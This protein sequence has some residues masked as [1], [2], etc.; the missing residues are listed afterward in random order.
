MQRLIAISKKLLAET[1]TSFMRYL[2]DQINWSGRMIGIRGPRGVGKT[3][4]MLQHIVIARQTADSL[5]VN[6]DDIYFA[7]HSLEA[8]AA[9]C[10]NHGI[11]HLYIDEVHKYVDWSRELKLIYD[12]HSEL[13][14]IFSGSSVLDINRGTADLT[15]RAVIYHLYGLSL[16]EY[17]ELFEGVKVPTYT[18]Q[19]ILQ[20]EPERTALP[21]IEAPLRTFQQYLE[22]G[23]Y[24]FAMHDDYQMK[25]RQIVAMTL[26]TDIPVF[27]GMPAGAARKLKALLSII[28]ASVPFKPNISKLATLVGVNRNVLP[29]Y[30]NLVEDAGMIMQLK[31][32]VA[33]IRALGKVEKVYLDNPNLIHALADL[34]GAVN[35]GNVRETFFVNQ[36]RVR[37]RV[38]ASGQADFAIGPY[39]FEVGGH[40]KGLRQ[41][42]GLEHGYV[43]KDDIVLSAG[44]AIPLWWFGLNY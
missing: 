41:I 24:P 19:Q 28:A 40:A 30:I 39:D 10:V 11:R 13:Q 18:L 15:R 38:T 42:Q 36:M 35:Q 2:Y 23:Y 25:L 14:V 44:R 27:A 37:N 26:E 31:E 8:L 5:Y 1:D 22:R 29:Q 21:L 3:T 9:D 6:A 7:N 12:Y 33:G 16:R 34:A 43:V 32:N 20:G 17:L 4:M